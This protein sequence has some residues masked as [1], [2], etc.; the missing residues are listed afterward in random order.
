MVSGLFCQQLPQGHVDPE[1]RTSRPPHGDTAHGLEGPGRSRATGAQQG[2][3]PWGPSR[4]GLLCA[5][6]GRAMRVP[7]I[8]ENRDKKAGV[9]LRLV[10]WGSLGSHLPAEGLLLSRQAVERLLKQSDI[11][12]HGGTLLFSEA[13]ALL[14]Q[15]RF[16]VHGLSKAS[17]RGRWV[18]AGGR[19]RP[20]RCGAAPGGSR[21]AEPSPCRSAPEL[22]WRQPLE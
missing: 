13:Q 18:A 1:T 12:S 9:P 11:F 5:V 3:A 22:P 4:H 19:R 7:V 17:E 10:S 6:S 20:G 8:K 2:S 14:Q 15:R 21:P 16:L